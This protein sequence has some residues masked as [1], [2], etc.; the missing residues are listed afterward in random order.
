M[1]L[2][3]ISVIVLTYNDFAEISGCIQNIISQKCSFNYEIIVIDSNSSDGTAEI[4]Q[5]YPVKF[6]SIHPHQFHHAITRNFAATIANGDIIIYMNGHTIPCNSTWIAN[7]EREFRDPEVAIVYGKQIP[8]EDAS[9]ERIFTLKQMYGD[10]R[11]VK[12]KKDIHRLGYSLYQISTVNAAI[13]RSIL[14][15]I[16]FPPS[17]PVFEDVALAKEIIDHGYRIIYSPDA[18]VFHSDEYT[19]A[20][21]FKRYFDIGV[22][23]ER[24]GFFDIK[25]KRNLL[26]DGLKHI[27]AEIRMIIKMRRFVELPITVI[28][29]TLKFTGLQLG[30][31]SKWLPSALIREFSLYDVFD[32]S[33]NSI[34]TLHLYEDCVK[35]Q[36]VSR[37]RKYAMRR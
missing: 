6:I 5:D 26:L 12:T 4:V 18:A 2:F 27:L 20:N 31:N 19:I 36:P 25:T 1:S 7:I 8:A 16:P 17:V 11:I 29:E 15:K 34:L 24:L 9:I 14:L 35:E 3:R 37:K 10:K 33:N 28:H 13:R 21:H 23:Y 30:K 22:I 32:S